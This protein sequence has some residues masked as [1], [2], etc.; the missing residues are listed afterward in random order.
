MILLNQLY[1]FSAHDFEVC[2]DKLLIPRQSFF[3]LFLNFK[4]IH[5]FILTHFSRG[6]PTISSVWLEK[7]LHIEQP[8]LRSSLHIYL[9]ILRKFSCLFSS[10]ICTFNCY[11]GD[12]RFVR[13]SDPKKGCIKTFLCFLCCCMKLL[14]DW[15]RHHHTILR[16]RS[17]SWISSEL[18]NSNHKKYC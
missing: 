1:L 8:V 2:K 9:V 18:I 13:V 5:L 12:R 15:V 4:T 10:F 3:F 11:N 16:M 6:K 14:L 17:L 7:A